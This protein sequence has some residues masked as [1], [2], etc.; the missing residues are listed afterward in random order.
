MYPDNNTFIIYP[1]LNIYVCSLSRR[2]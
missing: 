1:R 2:Y